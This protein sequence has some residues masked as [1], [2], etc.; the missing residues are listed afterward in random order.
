MEK[1]EIR[2]VIKYFVKKGLSATDIHADM[3]NTLGEAAPSFST[4]AKWTSEF[5]RGRQSVE[6][7]HRS[8]RP[9]TATTP[10]M[11]QKVH[12]IVM[13]DR[14]LKLREI[15]ETVGISKEGVGNILH[16]EL[17]M[18]KLSARW[19]PR[20]LTCDQ[21]LIRMRICQENLE[22]FNAT[23]PILFARFGTVGL[24]FVSTSEKI[25]CWKKI[26]VR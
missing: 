7:D 23:T 10:Q 3:K 20:L 19:V 8:G 1:I 25:S 5:K 15:A 9:K 6:D 4:V 17:G 18:K 12:N 13:E 21:K 11:I 24:P 16:E 2:A 22:R 26:F 14:R